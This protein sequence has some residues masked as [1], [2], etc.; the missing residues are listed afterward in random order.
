MHT[1]YAQQHVCFMY[2][3]VQPVLH[4]ICNKLQ[5][6]NYVGRQQ[7]QIQGG[8]GAR[9]PLSSIQHFTYAIKDH[10]TLIEQSP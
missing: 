4:A 9:A 8:M 3:S 7:G 6:C 10:N 1:P 2:Y 5:T